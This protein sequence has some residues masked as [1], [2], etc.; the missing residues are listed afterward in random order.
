MVITV[1]TGGNILIN[2]GPTQS[3]LIQPI[4]V[5]RLRG[6]GKWLQINGEAIYESRPWKFQ[7]DTKLKNIWFTSKPT[8]N[9][10]TIVYAIV[11]DY[12]FDS[13][14]V[15]LYSLGG[16]TVDNNTKA[17]MLGY[18]DE[19]KV[20]LIGRSIR[21]NRNDILF[22]LELFCF[23]GMDRMNRFTWNSLTNPN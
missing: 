21:K 22:Y 13:A 1:S 18:P 6:M 16:R 23:S 3:G 2:I 15:N 10:R 12:P 7:N 8:K 4:F 11:L 14:G 17:R 19:L 20:C 9:H 5:E